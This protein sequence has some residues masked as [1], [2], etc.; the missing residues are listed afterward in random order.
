MGTCQTR[1]V[2]DP[3]SPSSSR[4][5][6][7]RRVLSSWEMLSFVRRGRSMD[8]ELSGPSLWGAVM[9]WPTGYGSSLRKGSHGWLGERRA[10]L[11]GWGSWEQQGEQERLSTAAGV[12]ERCL[13]IP[14]HLRILAW[15]TLRLRWRA[16]GTLRVGSRRSHRDLGVAYRVLPANY[17]CFPNHRS[18]RGYPEGQFFSI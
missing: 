10:Q 18:P 6:G 17:R 4:A 1:Q 12:L 14:L 13:S 2:E 11:F 9:A 7:F 3:A 8:V 16:Y 5:L 15:Y